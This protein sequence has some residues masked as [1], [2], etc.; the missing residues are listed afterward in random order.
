MG[1]ESHL[2]R[3]T[4]VLNPKGISIWSAVSAQFTAECPYTLQWI[5]PSPLKTVH[6]PGGSGPPSNI[7]FLWPTRVLSPNRISIGSAVFL[8]S[9]PQNVPILKNGL[10][11]RPKIASPREDLHPHLIHDSLGPTEFMTQMISRSVQPSLHG[12]RLRQTD[13]QTD[14]AILC[15]NRPHLRTQ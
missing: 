2:A 4:R 7:R 15:N 11:F 1:M 9:S 14:H 5:A 13:R 3:L 8:H 12:S 10:P 6:S